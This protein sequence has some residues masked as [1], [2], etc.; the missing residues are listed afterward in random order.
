MR[1]YMAHLSSAGLSTTTSLVHSLGPS[2]L[3]CSEWWTCFSR[4]AVIECAASAL[5]VLPPRKVAY[6][7]ALVRTQYN[8]SDI[9]SH[10]KVATFLPTSTATTSAALHCQDKKASHCVPLPH[11]FDRGR[12][13]NTPNTPKNAN[14]KKEP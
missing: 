1:I 9:V 8:I 11:P 6:V 4:L 12:P 3:V 2:A 5:C 7:F 10:M 14:Y 13:P